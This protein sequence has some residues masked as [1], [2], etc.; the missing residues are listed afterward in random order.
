VE[1]DMRNLKTGQNDIIR[2]IGLGALIILEGLALVSTML[3]LVFLPLGSAYP[4]V[5]SAAIIILP[6]II[7]LI[8]QRFEA[9]I[10][11]SVLPFLVLALI[12]TTVYAP[13][14][15]IDLFQLGVLAG[16]VSGAL[17]LLGGMG[18]FGW[19]I[20]RIFLRSAAA[21]SLA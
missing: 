4:S 18:F 3:N 5:A 14:W 16:R 21:K 13:V 7:G 2:L 1:A 8:T 6:I 17:F 20:R 9:A 19:L 12:Y 11:L 10:V 15:N